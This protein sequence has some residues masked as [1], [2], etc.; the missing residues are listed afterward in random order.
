[1]EKFTRT[2]HYEDKKLNESIAKDVTINYSCEKKRGIFV[3]TPSR[4]KEYKTID[5]EQENQVGNNRHETIDFSNAKY[6]CI[7]KSPRTDHGHLRRSR[8]SLQSSKVTPTINRDS[9]L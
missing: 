9:Y 1:L 8:I 3:Y 2:K 7:I 6:E 4:E 5:Y